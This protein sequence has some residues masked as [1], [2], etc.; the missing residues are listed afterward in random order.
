MSRKVIATNTY[1]RKLWCDCHASSPGTTVSLL[2]GFFGRR[3]RLPFLFLGCLESR[4][5][6]CRYQTTGAFPPLGRSLER[7]EPSEIQ[8]TAAPNSS[9]PRPLSAPPLLLILA[10]SHSVNLMTKLTC[11]SLRSPVS[12]KWSFFFLYSGDMSDGCGALLMRM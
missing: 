9:T 11:L 7:L 10:N 4:N 3:V 6:C 12:D 2:A 1:F 8:N 5:H